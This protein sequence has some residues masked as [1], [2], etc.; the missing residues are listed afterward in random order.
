MNHTMELVELIKET[1]NQ[2]I[3]SLF[4]SLRFNHCLSEEERHFFVSAGDYQTAIEKNSIVPKDIELIRIREFIAYGIS[5]S[6]NITIVWIP[7]KTEPNGA[8]AYVLDGLIEDF[9]D[10][11]EKDPIFGYGLDIKAIRYPAFDLSF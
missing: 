6:R 10:N 9:E 5:K 11:L 2:D 1:R 3:I 7:I 4:L 8:W